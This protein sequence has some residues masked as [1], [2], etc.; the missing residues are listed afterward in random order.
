MIYSASDVVG[1]VMGG[2]TATALFFFIFW[3]GLRVWYRIGKGLA[4]RKIAIFAENE[5]ESLAGLLTDFGMV[6]RKNIMKIG[7]N[8]LGKAKQCDLYI[9]HYKP[10]SDKIERIVDSIDDG[11]MLIIYAPPDEGRL[12]QEVMNRINQHRNAITVN[13]RG[14][15]LNDVIF[16]M[17]TVRS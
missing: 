7:P 4:K 10:F 1:S 13:F 16:S 14:R 5:Y 8:D 15:L 17:V 6:N 3:K 2:L 9:V 11:K 12:E